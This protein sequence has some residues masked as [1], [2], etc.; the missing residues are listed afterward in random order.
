MKKYN[1]AILG[2]GN[3]GGE[4]ATAL[5]E[6]NGEIY[7]VCDINLEKAQ[8]FANKFHVSNVYNDADKMIANPEIDIV[9]ISTPH[10]LHY[11]F[12]LK[13]VKNGK[14]VF[15]E[16]AITVNAKQLDKVVAIAKEKNLVVTEGMT[17]YHMPL[18]KKLKEIVDSGAIGKVKMVQVNFGS[19]KEY[20]VKNRFFSKE[21]AGGALLDIGVYATSFARYFLESKPNVILTTAKYFETGVDEQSGIIMKNDRDQ[22]AVMALTM[23]AKQP[24]RGVVAGELGYIEVNNYPRA[25]KA[26]ITYTE[27]GRT[28]EI[29]LGET[30]K[31]LNY[32]V[33][34]MQEYITNKTGHEQ[35][36]LSIDVTH[37]LSEVRN[38]WGFVY[39][40]E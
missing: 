27:D 10:N 33:E 25:D 26:T 28:E 37:L 2:T 24:K 13:A 5:N 14:H 7:A 36:Q 17:L 23:R 6:V 29:K 16:K 4:M 15:C 21:L 38:Q 40:F 3:I 31:A 11:E 32:E 8:D 22:M 18:Y 30:A 12:L 9:Y 34:D 39:P 19:C 1:W 20:D 35:L